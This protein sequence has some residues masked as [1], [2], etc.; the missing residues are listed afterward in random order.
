M[1][2]RFAQ[3]WVDRAEQNNRRRALGVTDAEWKQVK[4]HRPHV[5]DGY[6]TLVSSGAGHER[7]VLIAAS[8]DHDPHDWPKGH[9]YHEIIDKCAWLLASGDNPD[10]GE[11]A[12]GHV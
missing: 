6:L 3:R 11:D 12:Q 5:R 2:K 9:N 1:L 8:V 7:A 10:F 4:R